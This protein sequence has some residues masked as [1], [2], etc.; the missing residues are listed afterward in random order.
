MKMQLFL[1]WRVDLFVI[2]FVYINLSAVFD[3]CS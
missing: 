2:M 3:A 1:V